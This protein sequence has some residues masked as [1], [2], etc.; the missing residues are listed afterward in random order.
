MIR[1]ILYIFPSFKHS[2]KSGILIAT[3]FIFEWLQLYRRMARFAAESV[4]WHFT[5]KMAIIRAS[6]F[7]EFFL[8]LSGGQLQLL[9]AFE[10]III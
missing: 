10:I 8:H 2:I 5:R 4:S 9:F 6:I 3:I 7:E 1:I